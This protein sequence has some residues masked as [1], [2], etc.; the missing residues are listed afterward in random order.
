MFNRRIVYRVVKQGVGFLPSGDFRVRGGAVA[1]DCIECCD[2]TWSPSYVLDFH[3]DS[4]DPY[5]C[6]RAPVLLLWS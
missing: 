1:A 5:I 3:I 6:T 4:F 2:C